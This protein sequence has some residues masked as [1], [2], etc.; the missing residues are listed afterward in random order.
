MLLG[1]IYMELGQPGD[2]IENL[3]PIYYSQ[4][5]NPDFLSLYGRALLQLERYA[6]AIRELERAAKLSNDPKFLMSDIALAKIASGETEKAVE[7]LKSAVMNEQYDSKAGVLLAYTQLS[8]GA[9]AEAEATALLF[10]K[11][12]PANPVLHNLLGTIAVAGGD[13]NSARRRFEQALNF[14]PAYTPAR[15]NLIKLD[16]EEGKLVRAE[17]QLN[18]IL[19]DEPDSR[20]ALAGL[21]QVA[22][23]RGD[24]ES[25]ALWLEKLWAKHPD[26]LMEVLRLIELYDKLGQEEKALSVAQRLRDKYTKNFDVLMALVNTQL[27]VGKRQDAIDT[28][29]LS[30][31]Y[32]VDFSVVQLLEIAKKQVQVEDTNGAYSTLGRC[33][34]QEPDFIPATVELIRLETRLRNYEKALQ[35]ADQVIATQT[36]SALGYSLKG[37]ILEFTG[38]DDEAMEFFEKANAIQPSTQLHLKIL[39]RHLQKN[40]NIQALMP[41]QKW[42][43]SNPEDVDAQFGLAV[44]YIDI[45]EY[46]K[47]TELHQMLLKKLP[48]DASIHNNLAWL[49]QHKQ[50]KKALEHA[51]KAYNLSPED[52]AVLDTY[53]WVLSET[54]RLEDGLRYIRQALSRSSKDPAARYHLALLLS[55]LNQKDE[56]RTVLGE[57]L[58]G[59]EDFREIA[60]ARSLLTQL[61]N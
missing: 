30:L 10:L 24:L 36:D 39:K 7:E 60:E 37:D 25:A 44:A 27:A 15:I 21:A 18:E 56:A 19:Q 32:T 12:E 14:D 48:D 4:D 59:N 47:A 26:V 16:L 51:R 3:K 50:D 6:D 43:Q 49:L 13:V 29:N 11:Q 57:L 22:E 5:K 54:G 17:K 40:K 31:R 53:G 9:P 23:M 61:E 35:L 33:L 46:D 41:L 55:R 42:T 45:K 20:Q 58:K 1:R 34:I 28:I 52:P 2:A 38:K 8:S